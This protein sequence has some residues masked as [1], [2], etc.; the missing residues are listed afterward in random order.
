MLQTIICKYCQGSIKDSDRFCYYCGKLVHDSV[1]TPNIPPGQTAIPAADT[2]K[3]TPADQ[4]AQAL[5]PTAGLE[6]A[7]NDKTAPPDGMPAVPL[8]APPPPE[9]EPENTVLPPAQPEQPVFDSF[10]LQAAPEPTPAA[11]PADSTMP[12]SGISVAHNAP[13]PPSPTVAAPLNDS[14]IPDTPKPAPPDEGTNPAP[15]PETDV[16][17]QGVNLTQSRN[18]TPQTKLPIQ[19]SLASKLS[20]KPEQKSTVKPTKTVTRLK[21]D[22][23]AKARMQAKAK[24]KTQADKLQATKMRLPFYF[25]LPHMCTL[26]S[27]LMLLLT[28]VSF[29][30]FSSAMGV[31]FLF[32]CWPL[33]L[34]LFATLMFFT[35][36]RDS[37]APRGVNFFIKLRTRIHKY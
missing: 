20:L 23:L 18:D 8:A 14:L 10:Q 13:E 37:Q 1:Q 4:A 36:L 28:V 26:F 12:S 25:R 6:T 33:G 32:P 24:T 30:G 34:L 16:P 31:F 22:L 21:A 11:E 3:P 35:P 7:T 29:Y 9:I 15:Q 19:S 5:A 27:I 17:T 2:Y